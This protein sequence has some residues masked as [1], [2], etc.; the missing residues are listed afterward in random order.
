MITITVGDAN[1]VHA[2]KLVKQMLDL[3]DELAVMFGNTELVHIILNHP[4]F[5]PILN[6]IGIERLKTEQE[7]KRQQSAKVFHRVLQAVNNEDQ[8]VEGN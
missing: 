2:K 4:I 1:Y 3:G 5:K 6:E 8:I 7:L